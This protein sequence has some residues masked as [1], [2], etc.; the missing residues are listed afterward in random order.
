MLHTVLYY[1]TYLELV[2]KSNNL[3]INV[4]YICLRWLTVMLTV[5]LGLGGCRLSSIC[6]LTWTPLS[7]QFLP[8]NWTVSSAACRPSY[9]TRSSVYLLARGVCTLLYTY[10]AQSSWCVWQ[11]YYSVSAVV[12]HNICHMVWFSV[13]HIYIARC[14]ATKFSNP[15]AAAR[16][17]GRPRRRRTRDT[18]R[19]TGLKKSVDAE[20]AQETG[21]VEEIW[22]MVTPSLLQRMTVTHDMT[23]RDM[24]KAAMI[25]QSRTEFPEGLL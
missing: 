12:K 20:T 6:L 1:V 9:L 21:H 22:H 3:L 24:E 17:R 15:S 25:Y 5:S 4:R 8:T 13:I 16:R 7:L 10:S 19:W 23:W 11:S 14:K 18:R 2:T